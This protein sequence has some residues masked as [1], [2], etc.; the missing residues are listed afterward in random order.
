MRIMRYVSLLGA[1]LLVKGIV[2]YHLEGDNRRNLRDLPS[3][4]YSVTYT[5]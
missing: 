5:R 4:S 3:C 2:L 1:A